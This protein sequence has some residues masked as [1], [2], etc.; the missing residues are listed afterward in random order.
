MSRP[1]STNPWL[2]WL[3][4]TLLVAV[5][6]AGLRWYQVDNRF[7]QWVPERAALGE[8]QSY[9]VVGGPRAA[10][11]RVV[12]DLRI[13]PSVGTFLDPAN[14]TLLS[15]VGGP[16]PDGF[17]TN[18]DTRGAFCFA[19]AGVSDQTLTADVERVCAGEPSLSVAGP[20]LFHVALNAQS[21]RRMFVIAAVI[22]GVGLVGVRL[23]GYSWTVALQSSAAVVGA[24]ALLLG[25][26]SWRGV[27]VDTTAS[28]APPLMAALG[29]SLALHRAGGAGRWML[30]GCFLTSVAATASFA[31][32][33]LPP[34]RQFALFATA[35]LTL[36]VIGVFLLVTPVP[37]D[38][39]RPTPRWLEAAIHWPHVRPVAALLLL[40]GV[41][42]VPVLKLS[43]DGL[44]LLPADS[45]EHAAY[46]ALDR[47]LTGMLPSQIVLDPP[48]PRA[49]GAM[50]A[51][52][53]VRKVV[54]TSRADGLP[55]GSR[56]WLLSPNDALPD[57][58]TSV[59]A[60]RAWAADN[61]ATLE[62]RGLA[63]QLVSAQRTI[64]RTALWAIPSALAVVAAA[65]GVATRRPRYALAAALAAFLPTALLLIVLAALR[66]G[67]T[68]PALLIGAITTGVAADD[69][70]HL[71]FARSRGHDLR[72]VWKPCLASSAVS[73]AAVLPLLLSPFPPTRQFGWMLS[74]A[75][76]AAAG[77]ALIVLPRLLGPLPRR[78]ASA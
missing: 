72:Y 53:G 8:R 77:S 60:W 31:V 54:D 9:V 67:V 29:F 57:L 14:V 74:L 66:V 50:A 23:V 46:V 34:L 13:L 39:A 59:P 15:Y 11:E 58:K 51:A 73:V 71:C 33:P 76:I 16:S 30:L 2:R 24:Q 64:E 19:A 25:T 68:P 52:A 12:G 56:F 55:P 3:C 47:E 18:G 42:A 65:I 43:D 40:G 75:L 22:V 6:A 41:A 70:L 45:R 49:A 44:A 61:G 48:R 20:A 28:I 63:A 32:A 1:T 35:G 36:T 62:W 17:V 27:A 69:I 26:L 10:F 4:W 37:F 38:V 7:D 78:G 21:Q 5:A